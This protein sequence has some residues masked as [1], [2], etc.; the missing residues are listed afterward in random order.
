MKGFGMSRL[1][2]RFNA[3]VVT[4]LTLAGLHGMAG[5]EQTKA[6][7]AKGMGHP[8]H[9]KV[10]KGKLDGCPAGFHTR[11]LRCSKRAIGEVA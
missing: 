5:A 9:R 4:V 11:G 3:A 6:Q 1:Q 8:F 2:Q 7:A 10:L